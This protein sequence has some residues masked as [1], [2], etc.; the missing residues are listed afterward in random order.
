M[1]IKVAQPQLTNRN[2]A[3]TPLQV[4]RVTPSKEGIDL[5]HRDAGQV[6]FS[7]LRLVSVFSKDDG[8]VTPYR[9][10]LF[11]DGRRR[12]F[13]AAANAIHYQAFPFPHAETLVPQLRSLI[14]YLWENNPSLAVDRRTFDFLSGKMPQQLS[15][16]IVVLATALS[17]LLAQVDETDGRS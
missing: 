15:Q 6:P 17:D 1:P 2:L 4:P 8:G 9:L 13:L 5:H 10:M 14:R 16:E 3:L 11:L 12:P 7:E